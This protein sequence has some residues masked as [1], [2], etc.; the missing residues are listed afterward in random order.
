[1]K[2]IGIMTWFSYNNY[3]TVLQVYATSKF[4]EK[5]KYEPQII[6]YLPKNRRTNMFDIKI[7]QIAKKVYEYKHKD[8]YIKTLQ[9]I[10]KK[11][12][13]FKNDNLKLTKV[14]NSEIDLI[15]VSKEQLAVICGSDQI[16]SPINF[17]KHYFLDFVNKSKKIAYA[18]SFGVSTIQSNLKETLKGL[19]NDFNYLSSREKKGQ[20]IIK[21]I[22]NKNSKLVVDPT[23]LLNKQ[24]WIKVLNLKEKENDYILCYFL[25]NQKEYYSFA[26]KLA[27]E[28]KLK[29]VIIPGNI[30]YA[31]KDKI[32]HVNSCGPKEFVELIMNA[33]Y[34]LTDSYHGMLF[35]INFNKNFI[36]FKRFKDNKK[37]SQNSRI[38]TILEEYNLENRMYKKNISISDILNH[39]IDYKKINEILEIKRKE[40]I[41]YLCS[42]I[43]EIEKGTSIKTNDEITKLCT[44]CGMCAS[45][46]PKKC[47]SIELS[48]NGFY[49]YKIDKSRC[50]NCGLCKKVCS[51]CINS[52]TR[53]EQKKL[54]S[55]FSKR[56]DILMS[57]S[58]GGIAYHLAE[59]AINNDIKVIGC[60]YDVK[61]NISK[62]IIINNKSDIKNLNGSKYLQSYTVD[63]F[64]EIKLLDKGMIIGT[65]C[66]IASINN[67]LNITKKRENFI[68]VDLICHGVPTYN[69]WKNVIN[70]Q[71]NIETVKFR[72]KKYKLKKILTINDIKQKNSIYY[73]FFNSGTIFNECCYDC[74]YRD[75]SCADIRI[76]DYWGPKYKNNKNGINMI[77]ANTKKGEKI[78]NLLK[79]DKNIFINK[80]NIIDYF[81]Y[82]QTKNNP[83]PLNYYEISKILE[84][85]NIDLRKVN[86][87]YIHKIILDENIRKKLHPIYRRFVKSNEKQ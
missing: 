29:I 31:D 86:R 32:N 63:A 68:L 30:H 24:E 48:K 7:S 77:I 51:Q 25:G 76:G 15:E 59:Y 19:I 55:G 84:G 16:W 62:H 72:D 27:K 52:R 20:E 23:L 12:V 39:E 10:T 67:Y 14:C 22:T 17:D 54:Y 83:L 64:K 70:K 8:K 21:D 66:Q 53:L 37:I 6:N 78:I 75:T 26:K 69:L 33:R 41:N 80:E 44:G 46:C 43:K 60:T 5:M 18:P 57:S 34:V 4:I 74:N 71:K 82:Q 40:S 85:Q 45:I 36:I 13:D 50:I 2:K 56:K 58:S 61:K 38:Y 28:T 47:I 87:K 65:P 81:K 35:S 3:G 11:S 9:N 1:M 79:N 73:D 42:A 49:N